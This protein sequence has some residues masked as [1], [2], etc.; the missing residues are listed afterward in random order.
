MTSFQDNVV[1]DLTVEQLEC[2][3]QDE[4]ITRLATILQSKRQRT[5]Q[6]VLAQENGAGQSQPGTVP[7]ATA[8]KGQ[9]T[10]MQDE[11]PKLP[12]Y[13]RE[14][15]FQG[16]FTPSYLPLLDS[17]SSNERRSRPIEDERDTG[18]LLDGECSKPTGNLF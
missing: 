14:N 11:S 17:P 10:D 16:L 1:E 5:N 3:A 18:L 9:A 12:Q 15:E 8:F 7:I 2:V 4:K 13:V 6:D